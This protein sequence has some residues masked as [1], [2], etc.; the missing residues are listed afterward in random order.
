MTARLIVA[1]APLQMAVGIVSPEEAGIILLSILG[2][3]GIEAA[4]VV[5]RDGVQIPIRAGR[6]AFLVLPQQLP[7]CRIGGKGQAPMAQKGGEITPADV[8]NAH[9][10]RAGLRSGWP[11]KEGLLQERTLCIIPEEV[12]GR[13]RRIGIRGE[14]DVLLRG[15]R[16]ATRQEIPGIA[17]M[18]AAPE[19][20]A[21][22]CV[23]LQEQGG[24][25]GSGR[26]IAGHIAVAGAVAGCI[27]AGR[28]TPGLRGG[29]DDPPVLPRY[30]PGR[31]RRRQGAEKQCGYQHQGNKRG[32]SGHGRA[33][34]ACGWGGMHASWTLV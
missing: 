21:G 18:G 5:R 29:G 25:I 24:A 23:F 12:P 10:E 13:C 27:R 11:G 14:E 30:L 17:R 31:Q 4:V 28:F 2:P 15:H 34:L 20:L 33:P 19:Q 9:A 8:V 3:G 1:D 22:G 32:M 26:A 6:P 16:E 7:C